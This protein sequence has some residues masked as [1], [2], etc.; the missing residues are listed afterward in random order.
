MRGAIHFACT[1][2]LMFVASAAYTKPLTATATPVNGICASDGQII[3]NAENTSGTTLY[4][5]VA[6]APLGVA[7]SKNNIFTNL[8]AGTYT[9]KVYDAQHATSATAFVISNII[10]STQYKQLS[11]L[12]VTPGI[13]LNSAV[14]G[15]N[16][17]CGPEGTMLVNAANGRSP[18]T[19]KLAKGTDTVTLTGNSGENVLFKNVSKGNYIVT[20]TDACGTSLTSTPVKLTND[21]DLSAAG[22]AG[23][24]LQNAPV[25]PDRVAGAPDS[26]AIRNLRSAGVIV[27]KD[28]AG[29]TVGYDSLTLPYKIEFTTNGTTSSSG[30]ITTGADIAKVG[31]YVPGAQASYVV[32]VKNPCTGHEFRSAPVTI[33]GQVFGVAGSNGLSDMCSPASLYASYNSSNNLAPYFPV[34]IQVKDANTG[35]TYSFTWTSGSMTFP[36]LPLVEGHKYEFAFEDAAGF[37]MNY[38]LTYKNTYSQLTFFATDA[39]EPGKVRIGVKG[40]FGSGPWPVKISITSAPSTLTPLPKPVEITSP[41][42]NVNLR[43]MLWDNLPEGSYSFLVEYGDGNNGICRI[44]N[45]NG[46]KMAGVTASLVVDS[47]SF[48]HVSCDIFNIIGSATAKRKDGSVFN[49]G[50]GDEALVAKIISGPEGTVGLTSTVASAAS[51]L[52][53]FR[54]VPAGDYVIGI[55]L[56]VNADCASGSDVKTVS[57]PHYEPLS[58]KAGGIV[59]KG[60]TTGILGIEAKGAG[61]YKYGVKGVNDADYTWQTDNLFYNMPAGIYSVKVRNECS[62]ITQDATVYDASTLQLLNASATAICRGDSLQ[63]ATKAVGPVAKI[64]WIY[65]NMPLTTGLNISGDT[66]IVPTFD[67]SLHAGWYKVTLESIAGCFVSDSVKI[68]ANDTVGLTVSAEP[69]HICGSGSLDL[70]SAEVIKNAVNASGYTFYSDAA[71]TKTLSGYNAI[72][73][74]GTYYVKATSSQGCVVVRPVTVVKDASC[75]AT[76]FNTWKTVK[77]ANGNNTA[78]AGELLTYNIYVRNTGRETLKTVTITDKVPAHTTYVDGGAGNG[79]GGRG[80]YSLTANTVSFTATNIPS[81]SDPIEFSFQVKV[82]ENIAG[83]NTISNQATVTADNID[84]PTCSAESADCKGDSTVIETARVNPGVFNAW[85]AVADASANGKAE[86]G[87]VLTYTIH[88]KNTGLSTISSV[89]VKD[90]VPQHTTYVSRSGGTYNDQDKSVVFSWNDLKAGADTS[91]SFQVKVDDQLSHVTQIANLAFVTGDNVTT[92]TCTTDDPSCTGDTTYIPVAGTTDIKVVKTSDKNTVTAIGA[93]YTYT[94]KVTNKSDY[95]AHN[96]VVVDT[97]SPMISYVTATVTVGKISGYD[98]ISRSFNWEIDV[99]QAGDEATLTLTVRA[100]K[101]G[102]VINKAYA[103]SDEPDTNP[104]DNIS[105]DEKDITVLKIPNVIT[106]NGDG[107]NDKFV[108]KN[109]EAYKENELVIF[110]RWNNIVYNKKNYTQDWTGQNL[111]AGTYFYILKVKDADNKWHSYNGYVMLMLN[112]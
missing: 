67:S 19:Y 61:P 17:L 66:L 71:T 99:M 112:K 87:E 47:L 15:A 11:G 39:C 77:D 85:K 16:G 38:S 51:P 96:V 75:N 78:E 91:V 93:N 103:S 82:D 41:G 36:G 8:P 80:T 69:L 44:E 63:I 89:I 70:S 48:Q 21:Y 18:I 110:N 101:A 32:V 24:S 10:V 27:L 42:T 90:T 49:Y 92:P 29:N 3:V 65:N 14:A 76:D 13:T 45:H 106:P 23:V 30:W 26:L 108:I 52:F 86:A 56:N 7:A 20:A 95:V 62:E 55:F 109:L 34:A 40:L 35:K 54:N 12:T 5:L 74:A 33:T 28:A 111:N 31:K 4:E 9:V 60:S 2:V 46:E 43:F 104:A 1:I 57:L 50:T 100:D 37:K 6:P 79:T 58:F 72:T 102:V 59:C 105:V 97:L 81:N 107:F 53:S 25:I 83:V 22:I 88:V 84:K 64:T 98:I 73:V 94:I 68:V